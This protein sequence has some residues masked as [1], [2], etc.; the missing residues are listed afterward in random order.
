MPWDFL[1]THR[2]K[3]ECKSSESKETKRFIY[4][5]IYYLST[6]S[7]FLDPRAQVKGDK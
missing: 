2:K 5:Y 4:I 1:N 3:Y 6:R 7:F